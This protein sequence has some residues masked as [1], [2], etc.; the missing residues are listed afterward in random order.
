MRATPRW[1]LPDQDRWPEGT[2]RRRSAILLVIGVGAFGLFDLP[3]EG[4]AAP[5]GGLAVTRRYD[6]VAAAT[7]FTLDIGDRSGSALFLAACP[8]AQV[9][10]VDGAGGATVIDSPTGT[11]VSF[12]PEATGTYRVVVAGNMPAVGLRQGADGCGDYAVTIDPV[13]VTR[14]GAELGPSTQ[15]T[16]HP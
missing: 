10:R 16:N 13:T 8:G 4:A 14:G 15:I 7:T 2:V 6:P 1:P 12:P 5:P 9:L 11:T 3:V